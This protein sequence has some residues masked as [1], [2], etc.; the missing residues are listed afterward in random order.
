MGSLNG[1][2]ALGAIALVIVIELL[3]AAGRKGNTTDLRDLFGFTEEHADKTLHILMRRFEE[4]SSVSSHRHICYAAAVALDAI[5]EYWER[6]CPEAP[7]TFG[8]EGFM[9]DPGS[10]KSCGISYLN[11]GDSYSPTILF[12]SDTE[13]FFI[14]CWGDLL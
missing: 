14:G 10:Q 6:E 8:V 1:L 3:F 12:N 4:A 11:T 7:M 9:F 13:K 5:A 2:Y